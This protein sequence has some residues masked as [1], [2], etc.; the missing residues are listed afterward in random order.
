MHKI[1]RGGDVMIIRI[2]RSVLLIA[3]VCIF[4]EFLF[5]CQVDLSKAVS[6]DTQSAIGQQSIRLPVIMYHQVSTHSNNLGRYV[7]S[8]S[9]LE[10]D[11]KY[12]KENGFT[13]VDV[14]DLIAYVSGD[15]KLP[16]KPIMLTFDD[17]YETGYTMLYP[18][19][20]QYGMCAVISV[21]GSLT[22]L[23]TQI[24]DHNDYYSYM[25]WDEVKQL[26][27]TPEIEI[28]NHSYDMHKIKSGGRKGIAKL[29]NESTDDY[30]NALYADVGKMQLMLMKKT[31]RA[32]TAMAYPF[33][34]YSKETVEICKK[35]G[36]K[37]S[38][39]CEEKVNT[40]TR[41]NADTLFNLGRYN[42]PSGKTSSVFF[43]KIFKECM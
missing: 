14:A 29:K 27:E 40:V 26:T 18:L 9:Q 20:K 39:T 21:V 24:D 4:A 12:I 36:F 33:G 37:C 17:G 7:I 10:N 28:Q 41:F 38:F 22:D 11:L 19:M 1:F 8:K 43:D 23:Y 5:F 32:A 15:G 35:L 3:A 13:A 42:R 2:R 25:T 6:N 16:E 30:Y 34:S 31:G